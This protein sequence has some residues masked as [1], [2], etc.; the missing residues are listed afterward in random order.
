M[1]GCGSGLGDKLGMGSQVGLDDFGAVFQPQCT[2]DSLIL[3][4]VLP[5]QM[6]LPLAGLTWLALRD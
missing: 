1:T 2:W 3:S 4:W 5:M 6:L